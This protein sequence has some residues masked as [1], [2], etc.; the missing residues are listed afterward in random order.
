[1]GDG[2]LEVKE[3]VN[4]I[5]LTDGNCETRKCGTQQII[6]TATLR[7][8]QEDRF[9]HWV[10]SDNDYLCHVRYHDLLDHEQLAEICIK[11]LQDL[12][13]L[14]CTELRPMVEFLDVK[15]ARKIMED[16]HEKFPLLLY[17]VDSLFIHISA[18]FRPLRLQAVDSRAE[19]FLKE[20]SLDHE[21]RA[22]NESLLDQL[23][24]HDIL[25]IVSIAINN[26]V[27]V[28]DF[29]VKQDLGRALHIAVSKDH[30]EIL[31]LLLNSVGPGEYSQLMFETLL[32]SA[33]FKCSLRSVESLL[34]NRADHSHKREIKWSKRFN[35]SAL[36]A[37]I[38]SR[39]RSAMLVQTL[40]NAGADPNRKGGGHDDQ[41]PLQ[42]AVEMG[43]NPIIEALKA[44]GAM[45]NGD[46]LTSLINHANDDWVALPQVNSESTITD[47]TNASFTEPFNPL[48][49]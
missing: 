29:P 44:A 42:A 11:Y 21:P 32:P 46:E 25:Q 35:G 22:T 12:H 17:A 4:P 9:V 5:H 40:L 48:C 15:R 28:R 16:A 8:T 13:T 37:A 19:D 34:Q 31:D 24:E 33:A 36:I 45:V 7:Q 43:Y 47:P 2:F 3:R 27:Q 30:F 14:R 20:R 10:T 6:A 26:S 1:M 49:G 18:A 41:T 39:H 23:V 38:K